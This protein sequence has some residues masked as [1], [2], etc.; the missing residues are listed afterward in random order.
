VWDLLFGDGN[1]TNGTSL[2]SSVK[3]Q[4]SKG[5]NF[6]AQLTV[7][8]GKDSTVATVKVKIAAGSVGTAAGL[9]PNCQGAP[10]V[11]I[12]PAGPAMYYIE[13]RDATSPTSSSQW[14]YEESNDIPGLQYT[15]NPGT[16]PVLGGASDIDPLAVKFKCQNG[17]TLDF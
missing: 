13:V 3:H 16:N 4:Y 5:G 11:T 7:T 1:K 10:Q 12:P 15:Q 8:D 2:P 6:T 14:M 17:D 9:D